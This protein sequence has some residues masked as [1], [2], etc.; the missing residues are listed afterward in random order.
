MQ[1][2]GPMLAILAMGGGLFVPLQQLPPLMRQIAIFSPAYGVGVISRA[3]LIGGLT[4]GAIAS[5]IGWTLIFGVGAMLLFR[6]DTAR[7]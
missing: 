5:V 1:F 7:V 3:P 6:R 4:T 2:V